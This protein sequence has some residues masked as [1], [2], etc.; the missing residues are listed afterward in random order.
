MTISFSFR[1]DFQSPEVFKQWKTSYAALGGCPNVFGKIGGLAQGVNGRG[2]EKRDLPPTS[3]EVAEDQRPYYL[4]A[5]ESLG[6]SR[7]MFE[8]NFPVEK[9]S[10]SYHVLWNAFKKIAADFSE[11][12][13]AELFRGAATRAYKL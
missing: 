5:I 9:E 1:V 2:W 11:D 10:V 7:C 12:E 8:S 13:K 6:P 3:D 4:H